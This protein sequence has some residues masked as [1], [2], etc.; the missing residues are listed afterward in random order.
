[1]TTRIWG[2]AARAGRGPLSIAVLLAT[3]LP[4]LAQQPATPERTTATELEE[5]IVTGTNA[6]RTVLDTP[7]AATSIDSDRLATLTASGQA[8][9]LNSVPS[10][11]A[12][13]G[14][15]EIAA[16]VFIKG[17]PS[18]GQYQFT[19]LQYDGI[20]VFSAFGLN[21][22]AFDVFYR[23]DLGIERLEF[24]RGGVSNLFGA[25]SVAGLINYISK[26]GT[27]T[28]EAKVQLE[29]A[30]KDRAR[31][32]FAFS[33]PLGA[34]SNL[35]YALS[36]FYRYD[37]GPIRT[38]ND[39]EGFQ[40]RGNLKREF[41]DGSGS[42]TLFAQYIDDKA[43]FYLPFPLDGASRSR[44]RGNDGRK[45]YSVQTSE[46]DGLGFQSP[47]GLFRSSIGDGSMTE[48]GSFAIVFDKELGAGWGVD[49]KVKYADYDHSFD[50]FLD[51]DGVVNV[52][53]TQAAFIANRNA[54]RGLPATAT[55][56]NSTFTYADTGEV[57]APDALLFP[58]RFI[59]RDRPAEDLTA[60]V[61]FTKSL[62]LGGF[63]HRFTIGGFYGS[64]EADDYNVTTSYLADFRNEARLV[65]LVVRDASG[66]PTT[67]SLNGLLNAGTG[68]VNNHHEAKRS[69]I[70][71]ADQFESDRFIFDIGARLEQIDGDIRRE[72]T[73][74]FVTD[75][76]TPNL[77]PALRDVI[78]GNDTFINAK[79]D[80]NEWA[81]ALGALYKLSDEFSLYANA[82]RGYF[83]P[84]LRAVQ[85]NA[86]GQPQ[87]YDAE[88]IQQGEVGVKFAGERF[89]GTLAALY[90][91]LNDRRAVQFVND[92]VT[93]G[94]FE[95][96]NIVS[97]ESYGTEATFNF[98]VT[99]DLSLEGNVTWQE[100]EFTEFDTTPAFIGNELLR[101]PNFLYNLGLY[102]DDGRFDGALYNT[103]TGSTYTTEANTIK[104]D[105]YDV[106]RL[107][108]GY[109][110]EW[111]AQTARLGFDVY[112]L[113]D[114]DGITEGSPRADISQTAGAYFVGR[115]VLPR[116]F[117]ARFTV[118]F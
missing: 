64:A 31:G 50:F 16:N 36:G 61:N 91:E 44:I 102:Y 32:D 34:D 26:T 95:R 66:N 65:N 89:S 96:V 6:A 88:I 37:E 114:G 52:P 21:S 81:L 107:D 1:M 40:L 101:Q 68:Y 58:N 73:A 15:G 49:S 116:R 62:Q 87:S 28:P 92:P 97:T 35:F 99:G 100:H 72:R 51:G 79:V 23:N 115:P 83:F 80:T 108:L 12:E 9:I 110:F 54:N 5:V 11:K 117:T 2:A 118:N 8:D 41:E 93:G 113:L 48:G 104:L 74:T 4:A 30:E 27:A 90:T 45:V 86:L 103:H 76:A 24:V 105:S 78:W 85:I 47:D 38:G 13:G 112:N 18:G 55:L 111:G 25:G 20:P 98:R 46:V 106:M 17:L 75:A 70:Y 67:Y 84:E 63:E 14:G 57:L 109:T 42:I 19:P 69:A 53:E 39:T 82:A 60:E 43:Q 71:L 29:L 7:L 77:A 94:V 22:S 3:P 56:A 59:D 10:I 33:G